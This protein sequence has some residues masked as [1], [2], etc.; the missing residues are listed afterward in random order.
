M[1]TI[2]VPLSAD[3]EKILHHIHECDEL[4]KLGRQQINEL[5][6]KRDRLMEEILANNIREAGN[7]AVEDKVRTVRKI[8]VERFK[9]Q[10]PGEFERLRRDEIRRAE[11]HAGE[12]IHLKDAERLLGKDALDPVCDLQSTITHVVVKKQ[13]D[14]TEGGP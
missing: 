5:Q 12:V 7:Y 4:M 10:F 9:L 6:G 8:D 13:N 1:R 3:P 11:L 2:S 14:G